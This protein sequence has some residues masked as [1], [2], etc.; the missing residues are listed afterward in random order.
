VS[1]THAAATVVQVVRAEGLA[2]ARDRA[3]DRL[4]DL[5]R[6]RSYRPLAEGETAA[7]Q[8]PILNLLATPPSPRFGGVPT[9]LLARLRV[10]EKERPLALLYP[11][12]RGYRL[13]MSRGGK[14]GRVDLA[15]PSLDPVALADP[16]FE[17]AVKA[18]L[19]LVGAW[20]LHVEGVAGLP[21][22]T[23]CDLRGP[24]LRLVVS[25]HD[26][27]LFCPRP[28]LMERP[29]E[30]FCDY[31]RDLDRCQRCLATDWTVPS[32]F[33]A[34]RRAVAAVLLANAD[35]V[36]YP[37]A[38]LR[39]RHADLFGQHGASRQHVIAPAV[40]L[41]NLG[42]P[43]DPRPIRH[44][45]YVGAVHAHKGALVFEQRAHVFDRAHP[46]ADG[47][48][49]EAALGGAGDHVENGA[50]LLVARRDVEEAELVGACRVVSCGGLDRIAG[51][52]QIDEFDA[53]DDAAFF[54]VEAGDE[55][56]LQH[57]QN[58]CC[59]PSSASAARGSRRPS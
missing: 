34:R 17:Q 40:D 32:G 26:F 31:C 37:S 18:A 23:L 15:A 58:G 7:F 11:T 51:V 9:Q 4:A 2:A 12:D 47:E 20:C 8:A 10:E 19:R 24:G 22:Q 42:P 13:E 53:F 1:L 54:H 28:H 14:R 43:R 25:V 36:I 6:D 44:I 30:R 21:L 46:A 38:F 3:L 5:R 52:A 41:P 48:R 45:A 29:V 59:A 39:D 16:A 57:G 49:H 50:P 33:Q 56:D 27:A 55:A 35:A